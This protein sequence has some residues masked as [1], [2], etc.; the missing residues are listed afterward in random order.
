MKKQFLL[1]CLLCFVTPL[2]SQFAIA[3]DTLTVQT[4]TF[5][6]IFKRRDTY[7]M[8]PATES[9]S[10]I[11]MLYTLKCDP[12]TPHDSYNCGEWDYLTYNTVY[13]HTGKFDSTKLTSKL[14]SFGFETPDTLFYSNNPRTY[15]IKK[16]KF[17]TTVENVVNEKTFDVSPRELV[18]GSIPGTAA[19]LQFT[20]TSKQ[21]R[22]LGIDAVNY[23]KLTFFST[24]EGKTLKNLT[25]KMRASSN[26]TDNH[27]ENSDFQTVFKGDYTIKAGYDQEIAFIEPFNW[28]SKFKNI[29]FD[30]S[31]EQSSQNDIL[32]DLS[33]SSILYFAY[34]NEYYMKFN[35][36]NDY[37]DCGNITEMNHTRK[38][39][40]EGWM[41]INKWIAN[42]CIFNKNNQFIFRTGNEVGK[43]SIIVNTNGSS[44]ANGTD[45]LKLNEWNHFAVVFDGTQ[46]TNQNRLKFYLNGKEILLTYSGEIPEY[47]PDNN[48][49]FTISSGMYKN[50]PFNGA[51]D[52]IR[53]WKDALS[54]ETI[55][56]FKDFALLIDHPNYSKIV[57][58]YDF[59]EHQ[60]HWIDDKS[61]NQNNGRMIGV[62]QIMS[63]TTD[64]IYLNI[65]QSDYI[66]S[67]SLSN[68][69]YSIKVDTLEEVETREIEQNS[70]IKYKVENNRLMIDTVHYY[71]PIGWVYDYDAD[72]NVIDSTLNESDGYYVNGD[73]EYYSEPFEIIDQTEIGRFI[74]P[75]G[76]NLDL[77]PEG[78]TWMYDVT[79][80]APL[81][82]DTVDFGA[83]NLQELIDVKFLFIKGTP[84]RNVK[85]INKLW[86]TNQNSIRYA[87]LSDDTKLS[88][89]NIDLLPDTKSLKLKTRLSGHGHNSD[90]GNY[91]HC[92]EWKD[93][94]HR[95]ISNSSE[96]AS[97]HIWQTNDCAENPVYPQ[98]GTWPGSREGW[99][100]GDVVKDNDFEVGQFIS[101]NQLNIDYDITKV[102]QDNLGMG[103]G[104]Y[105]VSMQLFE[106]GDYSYE[107]DAEIYDVIMPSSKDY[108]SRTNP[109]CSDPT[110]IIRNNSANDL[111]ALDFEYE[112][113]GGY[114]ANYKWEGTIPPMKTEKIALPIPAS[115]FW[116]G[117]GTNK[118]SVKISNPNGNTDDND[119]NNTFISD[120][121]MPDLY[122]YSAKVVLKT[123][124]RGSNFSYKLSDVQGNV[125]D[126]KPSLG[127]NTNYE[128]PLD[129]PQGCYTL[130]V[131]DLYNYGL[132]YWAYPEQGS[133]YL[134]I[135]D[136]SG[137]T[138]KTFN[139]DFGHGIKYSFFVGS[140]TLVHEPNLNEMVYLY[141]NP[142]ENTLNLT[143]NEIAGNVGI[144]VYDNLGNMK[145]AQ[146]FNVSPNSIVTLNTTNLSTGN[147]IVEI[148]N[149]TTILTKKFIKK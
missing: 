5:D 97:W 15:K 127:S 94:T 41:N 110:I 19:H 98:G 113:I 81:L 126:H 22:D 56:S 118:F 102:P 30:I 34:L 86:G 93:N 137:K 103:N 70:I 8:P 116:I 49:S 89:T 20:L 42:E 78:F 27:F 44:S 111:T 123:N 29:N 101:N 37:I 129:L 33:S 80:Y 139:P 149:G 66:P 131:Y 84:P 125:I 21:L 106:Y 63:T 76:I 58:Y 109:I 57:A 6:D 69:T 39:T 142:S 108:Y 62:P 91:P 85:R 25:I 136:G 45:V 35:S 146:V 105:V 47:T 124:L 51:I 72:G 40:V 133:G 122:E 50:A 53:I 141:P 36:P 114:S 79:D 148:N 132:S 28:N 65:N 23:D 14:Y 107:N 61:P 10:K 140:Y 7:V 4:L 54:Q 96:I 48:A 119:A 64:E 52:E 59:N 67:L 60:S 38:L 74:T 145:I 43:I 55:S 88:E 138:L 17:K 75:Y 71:Y 128:I 11:L 90:D 121:N 120:F 73:L 117:D 87:A 100:P 112:I 12:K 1:F 32:F 2:F 99:C 135:H 115:E 83:G 95:L 104:N 3:G 24:S 143:L 9:F 130:E 134:N 13:S 26:V 92:C 147:Y 68:G 31:F 144:K 77:G 46:S 82:H 18:N 16:Q